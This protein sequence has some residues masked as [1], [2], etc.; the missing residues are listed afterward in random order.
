MNRIHITQGE[1]AIGGPD[2]DIVVATVL[3][4]CVSLCMHDPV[5]R[6]GGMNHMLLADL[7]VG[8]SA[9]TLGAAEIE[10][11]INA[12]RR[13]GARPDRMRAKVFGGASM[14]DG[15]TD[16]GERNAR[17][18]L[19]WLKR[20]NIAIEARSIG[21]TQARQLQFEPATGVA[22]QRFVAER[23]KEDL[24]GDAALNGVEML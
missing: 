17:F 21:G 11:L 8:H 22:R 5:A 12:M 20:E 16:I 2:D 1:L 23:P 24:V 15:M 10:R 9:S 4:S 6:A 18:A 13:L 19:F 3:G 14:L 7:R